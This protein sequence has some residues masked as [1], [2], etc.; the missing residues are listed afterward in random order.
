MVISTRT[1][2]MALQNNCATCLSEEKTQNGFYG[3]LNRSDS[4][5]IFDSHTESLNEKEKE[6]MIE[7]VSLTVYQSLKS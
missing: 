4:C 7:F 5:Q 6:N 1:R 3:I 2:W